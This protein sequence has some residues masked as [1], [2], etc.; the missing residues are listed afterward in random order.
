MTGDI[1]HSDEKYI[2]KQTGH[3]KSVQNPKNYPLEN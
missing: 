3:K 2:E 1:V